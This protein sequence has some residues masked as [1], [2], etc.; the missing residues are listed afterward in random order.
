MTNFTKNTMVA[1][2]ALLIAAGMAGAQ[3]ITAEV[4]FPFRTAGAVL[5]AGSYQVSTVQTA[6]GL[7]VFK[8]TQEDTHRSILTIPYAN[9]IKKVG[10]TNASLTF[11]CSGTDCTLLEVAPG[12]GHSYRFSKPKAGSD[13][14][15]RLAVIR[16]VLANAR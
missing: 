7:A 6:G 10:Q 14:D 3:T 15:T 8:L 4:P 5:P 13:G 11:E 1:A 16:A 2:A 9:N 12:T